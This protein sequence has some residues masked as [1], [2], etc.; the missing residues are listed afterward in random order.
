MKIFNKQTSRLAVSVAAISFLFLAT[1]TAFA[2]AGT[3]KLAD[4]NWDSAQVHNRIA[5]FILENGYGYSVQYTPGATIPLFS[6][7]ARGDLDIEMECWVEN[8]QEAF[9]KA[10]AD[11]SVVDLG[12]NFPDSWQGWLVPTY[13]IEG[14]PDRGIKPMAP[15]LK[16]IQDLPKYWKI[17]RDPE[18]PDKGRFYSCIPGW[19]CEKI[20]EKK[21]KAYGLDKTYNIFLPGSDAAL[22]GS[23]A[24]A[25]KKGEPWFGYY[26]APTWVLGKFDMTPI[27]EQPYDPEIWEENYACAYPSVKVNIVVNSSLLKRAPEVVDFLKKYETTQQICNKFLAYMQDTNAGTDEAAI[28]FL[29]NFESLWT[30]WVPSNVAAKVK[31]ALP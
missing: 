17:F 22:N 2:G 12:S 6:G 30:G 3:L 25:Y 26:W 19:E 29:K 8:Q 21:F 24:A 16:S 4:L 10:I 27:Q 15:D 14:D 5:G 13:V 20:N 23:M 28:W 7:L 31:A 18:N 1:A 9:D 11:G